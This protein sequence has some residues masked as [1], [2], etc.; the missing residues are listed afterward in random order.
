MMPNFSCGYLYSVYLFMVLL[1]LIMCALPRAVVRT[2]R[3]M[4][5]LCVLVN[6]DV[7]FKIKCEKDLGPSADSPAVSQE[8]N[9]SFE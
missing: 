5:M 4:S 9:L 6:I 8:K 1:S 7:L 3:V 2:F